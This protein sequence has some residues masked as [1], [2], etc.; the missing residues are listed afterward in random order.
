MHAVFHGGLIVLEYLPTL[1]GSQ[2]ERHR[3]ADN[4]VTSNKLEDRPINHPIDDYQD[5]Q[6]QYKRG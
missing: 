1:H 4:V 3:A 5:L 2:L 6:G